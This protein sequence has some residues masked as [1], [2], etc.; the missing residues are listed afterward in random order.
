MRNKE[1]EKTTEETRKQ[2][3]LYE[4]TDDEI[5]SKNQRENR[6]IPTSD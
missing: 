2:I 5:K 6:Y 1:I 4:S 3:H